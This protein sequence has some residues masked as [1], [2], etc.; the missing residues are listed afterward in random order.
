MSKH[1]G[2]TYDA[3]ATQYTDAIDEKPLTVFYDRPAFLSLLIA[4]RNPLKGFHLILKTACWPQSAFQPE[5]E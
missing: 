1:T 3:I 5:V 2:N 4:G